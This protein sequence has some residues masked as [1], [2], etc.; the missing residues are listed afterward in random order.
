MTCLLHV[1][2]AG[3]YFRMKYTGI[4]A[5][6]RW[7]ST[8]SINNNTNNNEGGGRGEAGEAPAA[9]EAASAAET[10]QEEE[11]GIVCV[12]YSFSNL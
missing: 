7:L 3:A 6:L 4:Y 5:L 11:E 9:A 8:S 12:V 2:L 1:L 10:E